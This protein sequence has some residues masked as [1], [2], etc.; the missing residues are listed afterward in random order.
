MKKYIL[1][2]IIGIIIGST[3]T[4]GAAYVY[5]ARDISYLPNDENWNVSN[6]G[7][8]LSSLK[9]DLNTV[10]T[11]VT[12]YKQQI[13]EALSDKGVSV[14][15]NSSM[16]D[17]TSGISNMSTSKTITVTLS[18]NDD[19]VNVIVNGTSLISTSL[20]WNNISITKTYTAN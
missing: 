10:N 17:I 12:E 16:E 7:E 9:E 19:G 13:T 2:T 20:S 18:G 4:A 8:A 5:S 3:I 1:C 6:A 15:E 11:N 14:D